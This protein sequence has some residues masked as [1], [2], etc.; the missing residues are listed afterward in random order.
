MAHSWVEKYITEAEISEISEAV[1]LAEAN[2]LGDIVPMIVR[3]SSAV[4]HVP[5]VLALSF[6]LLFLGVEIM[7]LNGW[8]LSDL[9]PMFYSHWTMQLALLVVLLIISWGLAHLP[10][11]QRMLTSDA[12]EIDQVEKRAQLEFFLQRLNRT[13]RHSAVLIFVS[14]MERRA[15]ILADEGLAKKL[16]PQIWSEVLKP[17]SELLGQGKWNE[18]LQ[19]AI[20]RSGEL[21]K[22]HFPAPKGTT[23]NEI[24]NQLIIKE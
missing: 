7:G 16:S 9:L 18:G 2:T 24:G 13:H 20:R 11:V 19:D 17:L 8:Y 10:A 6:T 15:V 5:V 12:D 3:R 21:L 4:R 23:A 14:V 1:G 22:T